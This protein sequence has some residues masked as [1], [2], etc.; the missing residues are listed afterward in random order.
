MEVVAGFELH[1]AKIQ[2]KK[3]AQLLLSKTPSDL[4]AMFLQ[5]VMIPEFRAP[6]WASEDISKPFEL[7]LSTGKL[8]LQEYP[9]K[10][11]SL[12]ITDEPRL[13]SYLFLVNYL[14]ARILASASSMRLV[15]MYTLT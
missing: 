11:S 10:M 8:A 1:A 4:I 2:Q 5:Y 14:V 12:S 7:D 15:F 3:W 6:H 13:R 9:L